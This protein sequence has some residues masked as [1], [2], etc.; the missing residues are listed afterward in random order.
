MKKV[1]FKNISVSLLSYSY[2]AIEKSV[3]LSGLIRKG[4]IRFKLSLLIS[5]TLL[6][7]VIAF[8]LLFTVMATN[9]AY[10]R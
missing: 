6:F 1:N 7:I 8:I 10:V 5:M 4:G 2:E 3:T 9:S